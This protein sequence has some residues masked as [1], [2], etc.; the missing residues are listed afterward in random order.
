MITDIQEKREHCVSELMCI[1]CFHRYIGVFPLATQ[2][3]ALE[4]E[5]CGCGYIIS[6]GQL[7]ATEMTNQIT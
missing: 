6:T 7:I 5:K 4:C 2:L 1:K 3:K